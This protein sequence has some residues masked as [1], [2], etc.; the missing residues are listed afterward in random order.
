MPLRREHL[1]ADITVWLPVIQTEAS[2]G[3]HSSAPVHC[4]PALRPCSAQSA[5]NSATHMP[6]IDPVR[7]L[8]R[9][10][11]R[12]RSAACC[13]CGRTPALP[14]RLTPRPCPRPSEPRALLLGE[15]SL[16]RRRSYGRSRSRFSLRLCFSRKTPRTHLQSPVSAAR[17]SRACVPGQARNNGGAARAED[18]QLSSLGGHPHARKD[19]AINPHLAET[20][21]A[22]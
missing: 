14:R 12:S 3:R 2:T 19:C 15:A 18:C 17:V 9:R 20:W 10:T 7:A 16:G 5:A 6:C 1:L 8:C 4:V 13:D 21:C 22:G 11:S